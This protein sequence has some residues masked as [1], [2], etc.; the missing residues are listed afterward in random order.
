M[1][2]RRNYFTAFDDINL[3]QYGGQT[4]PPLTDN[5]YAVPTNSYKAA[6]S[7]RVSEQIGD[8]TPE[9]STVYT[10]DPNYG[11]REIGGQGYIRKITPPQIRFEDVGKEIPKS[12]LDWDNWLTPIYSDVKDYDILHTHLPEYESIEY[13]SK[14]NGTWLKDVYGGDWKGDPRSWV[15][16]QSKRGKDL[17]PL[18]G[19]NTG[20]PNYHL[21]T[22]P[23]YNGTIWQ[24]NHPNVYNHFSMFGGENFPVSIPTKS[25]VFSIEAKMNDYSEL[26]FRGKQMHIE[27]IV[28]I[29]KSE[30]YDAVQ[31]KNLIEGPIRGNHPAKGGL[32]DDFIIMNG[33]S[34]KSL[35]G[36]NGDFDFSINNKFKKYGGHINN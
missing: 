28:R 36:N 25:K 1:K 31:I 35:I 32:T 15:Q 27:D 34:S 19:Y 7:R 24:A 17:I 9:N 6:G 30:G 21:E 3:Y 22:F 16:L 29:L 13:S 26:P 10:Y 4:D 8:V 5:K 11:Y 33:T 20:V 18:N 2:R 14:T 12:E 23:I